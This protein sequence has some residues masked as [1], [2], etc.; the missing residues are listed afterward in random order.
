M[1]LNGYIENYK[2]NENQFFSEMVH[3]NNEEWKEKHWWIDRQDKML[4]VA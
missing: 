4:M 1:N 2:S 3:V